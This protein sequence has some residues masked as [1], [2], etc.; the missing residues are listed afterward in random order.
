[1]D[2][3]TYVKMDFK[4]LKGPQYVTKLVDENFLLDE[5]TVGIE[6]FVKK[7]LVWQ[8][9]CQCGLRSRK[10]LTIITIKEIYTNEC[11]KKRFFFQF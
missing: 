6:K 11:L 7:I 8:A 9:I 10:F 4:T 3:E 5:T 2:D 1:M